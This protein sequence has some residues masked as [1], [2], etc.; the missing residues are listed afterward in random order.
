[1]AKGKPSENIEDSKV[2]M[3]TKV[4]DMISRNIPLPK[5]IFD[6]LG[7]V[8]SEKEISELFALIC[9][10]TASQRFGALL[11]LEPS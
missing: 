10:F 1:M 3:A 6:D 4:S 5:E 9:F 8:F 11:E 2:L 7:K